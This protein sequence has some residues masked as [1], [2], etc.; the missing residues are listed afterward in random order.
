MTT[1]KICIF[2]LV[3]VQHLPF[4]LNGNYCGILNC[5][6]WSFKQVKL[7]FQATPDEKSVAIHVLQ[8][9]YNIGFVLLKE[10][11]EFVLVLFSG[12]S[13]GYGLTR[14]SRAAGKMYKTSVHSF[15]LQVFLSLLFYPDSGF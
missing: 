3:Y 6:K 5:N 11:L 9:M 7:I 13:T 10:N 2:L 15:V 4:I 12:K 14:E 1:P 8:N